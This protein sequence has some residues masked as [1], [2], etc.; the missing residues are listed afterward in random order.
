MAFDSSSP[1]MGIHARLPLIAAC[2]NTATVQ[3]HGKQANC[4]MSL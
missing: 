3:A 2:Y 4:I 1:M